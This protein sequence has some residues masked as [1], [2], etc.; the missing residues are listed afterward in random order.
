MFLKFTPTVFVIGKEYEILVNATEKG[1]FAVKIGGEFF[2]AENSG[3]LSSEKTYAKIRVPQSALDAAEKY[4]IVYKKTIDR[5]GY[6][7]LMGEPQTATFFFKP[8]KKTDNIHI[9]HIADVHYNYETAARTAS[10]FGDDIDLFVFNGDIGEVETEENYLETAKF[11]GEISQGKIPVVFTRGNHDTRG[12]LA[13]KYVEY[14]P[15]DGQNT[16]FTFKLGC[17][18][19]V[20]LDCGEDKKDD[21]YD[22][23]YPNPWVYGGVNDF[24]SFRRREYAW[25]QDVASQ[26]ET[27][28]F[29]ICHIPLVRASE[30]QGNVFDIEREL[31]QKMS[32]ELEKLGI[33]FLLCGHMHRAYVLQPNDEKSFV[34]HAYPVIVGSE[35]TKETYDGGK[36]SV[37]QFIGTAITLKTN[38]TEVLF[39]NQNHKITGRFVLK[40]A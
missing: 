13:E 35:L 7:S 26:K 33:R 18:N 31:Y 21:H 27:R 30:V 37:G 17:I 19:G 15:A 25:L 36:V 23:Q 40:N 6:F 11:T 8:L 10:Y 5:K 2:Y 16:Y 29:A 20:V 9:Y 3:V 1:I 34:K 28:T 12:K 32:L 22:E 39:T 38:Q 14:F 24:Y 4:E